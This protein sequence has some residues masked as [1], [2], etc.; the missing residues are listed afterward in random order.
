MTSSRIMCECDQSFLL[1]QSRVDFFHSSVVLLRN[2]SISSLRRKSFHFISTL[3]CSFGYSGNFR[4]WNQ[5]SWWRKLSSEM[6][7]PGA[8]THKLFNLGLHWHDFISDFKWSTIADKFWNEKLTT[9]LKSMQV[10][11]ENSFE[12]LDHLH[13]LISHSLARA[14][15][16]ENVW[17]DLKN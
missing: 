10:E 16:R 2:K 4:K 14:K 8:L 6:L 5:L 3:L 9:E 15:Q 11:T 7:C 17:G 12:A 13:V 1:K